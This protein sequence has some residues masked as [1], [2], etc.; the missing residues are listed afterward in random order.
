M[1]R[2]SPLL[3]FALVLI[4]LLPTAAGR[5]ILDLAGGLLVIFILTPFILGGAGWIGW[6]IIQSRIKKCESCGTSFFNSKEC[7]V[8]GSSTFS[9]QENNQN[10][11]N[12]PASSATVDITPK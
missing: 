1:G 10:K 12:I 3:F 7:P 5:L 4:F 8:C 11:E 2:I 9:D 6:K